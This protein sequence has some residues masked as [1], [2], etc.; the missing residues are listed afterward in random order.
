M[1]KYEDFLASKAIRAQERGLKTIPPLASHLFPFQKLCVD[2]ALRSGSAGNFLSTGLGKTA[3]ELEWATHAAEASNGKALI[4]A[5]LSVGWQIAKEGDR[6]GYDSRVV[7]DQSEVRSGINICNYDRLDKL[8]PSSFGAVAL[9][10][11]SI[12]K[13]FG[14]VP[15]NLDEL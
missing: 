9:D 1:G 3:C 6:W 14:E 11:S 5:P 10:E 2:F 8:D 15:T 7:R 4:L 13:S 12:L